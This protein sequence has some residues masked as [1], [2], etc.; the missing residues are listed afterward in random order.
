MLKKGQVILVGAGPGDYGLI[1]VKGMRAIKEADVIVYDSLISMSLLNDVKE[2]AVLIYAGKRADHHYL[3]QNEINQAL[4]DYARKGCTVVRLK[5]GDPFI[6][7]RGGEE[8][9][10][11][12]EEGIDFTIIPGISSSYSVPAYQGIPVTHRTMASSVHIITG[13]E[14]KEKRGN[15]VFDY[16]ILAKEE[17]TLVF[18][19]GLSNL[20][21]IV[22]GL[23][24]NGKDPASPAA[25]LQ[26]GTTAKQRGAF[27]T[28]ST[29]EE[30]C[31]RKQ[32]QTPAIIVVGAVASLSRELS[33]F[34][35]GP[36]FGNKIMATGTKQL[37]RHLAEEIKLLGGE[38]VEFSLINTRALQVD[39][40][41]LSEMTWAVF[42]SANGVEYFF[43]ALKERKIDLRKIMHLKFAVI[44]PGT[45]K[46]LWKQGFDCDYMPDAFSS[47]DMAD[48]FLPLLNEKDYI[49]LFRAKEA[50]N[51]LPEAFQKNG[52]IRFEE[53][54][55]YDTIIEERKKEE[56][57]RQLPNIDYLTFASSSAVN[58][59]A[60]MTKDYHGQ[61]PE[62]ISIGPVTTKT[63]EECG[64]PIMKTARQYTVKGICEAILENCKLL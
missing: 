10:A 1:T 33:W 3:K 62:I 43:R 60:K 31:K 25:V 39:F 7:G 49:G 45:K 18:L 4:I 40:S 2:E 8:A 55:L 61:M 27:A 46:A 30:E 17:G 63:L 14:S 50:S 44:G 32:I 26:Q 64:Y 37:C 58:A 15:S 53:I 5:G 16:Q 48:G 47:E 28:L 21:N 35:K 54:P 11:L 59:F 9:L 12:W 20:S 42:T 13:H 6:F 19:M 24:S 34:E 36:L 56:L 38:P 41:H 23:I 52:Q 22:N 29:I 57:L 51:V